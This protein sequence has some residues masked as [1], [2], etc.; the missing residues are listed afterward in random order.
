[1]SETT[2]R[3]SERQPAEEK[4]SGSEQSAPVNSQAASDICTDS[5]RQVLS[6]QISLTNKP[7]LSDTLRQTEQPAAKKSTG[8]SPIAHDVKERHPRHSYQ[9]DSPG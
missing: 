7:S 5:M 9:R 1:M 3:P 2:I 8:H 4:A 6:N